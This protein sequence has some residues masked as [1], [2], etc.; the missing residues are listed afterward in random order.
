V[1][2]RDL[3][4]SNIM[5]GPYGETLVVDWGLAKAVG[6]GPEAPGGEGPTEPTLLP[7]LA[8]GSAETV[9]GAALG[10]P[11]YMSPEQALGRLEEL[12]PPSDVYSLGA[13]LYSILTGRP[14]I[15]GKDSA[16][17]LRKAQ[18]GEV[19]PPRQVKADVPAALD[20]VC[21][22]AMAPRPDERYS[23]ALELAADVEQ[24]LGDEPV[25][26]Y[27]DPW[28]ARARR[29]GRRHRPLVTAA[30]A[31]LVVSVVGLA[32]GLVLLTAAA[33]AEATARKTAEEKED[34]AT[35]RAEEWRRVLY[36]AEMSLAQR[37]YEAGNID[38]FRELLER[39]AYRPAGA[40]DLRGFE[41]HYWD[42][43]AHREV[44]TLKGHA[45]SVNGVAWCPDGRRLASAGTD[46][47]VRLWDTAS[48]R[49]VLTLRHPDGVHGVAWS[50]DGKRLA[51]AG[52]D[53]T[54]RL[55]DP[56]G[57]RQVL[58]LKGHKGHVRK[59]AWSPD[60]RRLASA[61]DDGTLRL[62]NPAAAG[63]SSP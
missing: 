58:A 36:L 25:R 5:L 21:R 62:W 42:W 37:E 16:E 20:A 11:A 8:D 4:P 7:R 18:K 27:R 45:G 17:L 1:I 61:G 50:P 10:T 52:W 49:E 59:V 47:T 41:W 9:A 23:S 12:G 29:W 3:K 46:G 48:G 24:W 55:W 60:G 22:K 26:A 44:H 14:P 13:T 56:A 15:G 19:P 57:G 51:S 2:H 54:V 39:Q 53:G 28:A 30:L 6:R 40:E 63:K 31:V 38:H 32:V 43:L 34:E 35:R 33:E